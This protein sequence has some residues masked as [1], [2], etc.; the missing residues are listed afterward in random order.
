M[1]VMFLPLQ[2]LELRQLTV[3]QL[4]KS[5]IKIFFSSWDQKDDSDI[6]RNKFRINLI[7]FRQLFTRSLCYYGSIRNHIYLI[8]H[9]FHQTPLLLHHLN[10]L[11]Q[12]VL[13]ELKANFL[14]IELTCRI[15]MIFAYPFPDKPATLIKCVCGFTIH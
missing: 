1:L 6:N 10:S 5:E 8:F 9:E 13:A 4:T 7:Y 14:K 15:N 2:I 11:Q 12:S 3:T